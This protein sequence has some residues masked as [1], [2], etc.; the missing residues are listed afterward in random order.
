LVDVGENANNVKW[1]SPDVAAQGAWSAPRT[2]GHS[3]YSESVVTYSPYS[4]TSN[5]YLPSNQ[6]HA[7]NHTV[8]LNTLTTSHPENDAYIP[9]IT[10]TP[11]I[12]P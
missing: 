9:R 5:H 8:K 12:H 6:S 11:G 10:T 7:A 1:V 2:A 3:P 4:C